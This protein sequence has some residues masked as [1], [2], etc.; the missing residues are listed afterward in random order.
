MQVERAGVGLLT[1]LGITDSEAVVDEF[2]G[3]D[4]HNRY[5]VLFLVLL[6]LLRKLV[7]L[8]MA[9]V[10]GLV[11]GNGRQRRVWNRGA[12]PPMIDPSSAL[13]LEMFIII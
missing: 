1:A 13:G 12:G 11:E 4:C 10:G 8:V 7:V 5:T 2:H 3:G 9:I 6:Q